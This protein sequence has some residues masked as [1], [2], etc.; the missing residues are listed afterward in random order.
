MVRFMAGMVVVMSAEMPTMLAECSSTAA[1]NFSGA[2][3][4]PRLNTLKPAPSSII[5]TR[6][7]P[8]SCRSPWAVPITTVPK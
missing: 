3:S 8:M 2:T 7:L 4:R 6:F 5:A 1:T